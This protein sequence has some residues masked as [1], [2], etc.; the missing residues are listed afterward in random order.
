MLTA[1][2]L[3]PQKAALYHV[4][5]SSRNFYGVLSVVNVDENYLA[6]RYGSTV[7]GFQYRDAQRARLAT[8]YYGPASGANI[9]IR[10]WPQHPM[11]VG[12][13]GLGVGTLAALAQFG[14]VF[15]F[16]EINPDVYKLSTGQQPFFTY[17]RDSPGRIEVI[18]GDARLSL[19]READRGDFQKFDVLVLDAFSSDAIPMHLL[20]R[21]AFY[22]YAKHLRGPASVI[23]VHISNQTLDLGPV[24][25]GI[26]RDFGFHALRVIP[27]LL[28]TS[29]F[30]QSD[31]ILLSRDLA[32]LSGDEIL[33]R[34]EPF[35]AKTRPISW[36]DD[37]CDL[38]HVIRWED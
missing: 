17:L 7:H 13:V 2:L 20:T 37:Y 22:V 3:I 35:P 5:A 18:L 6:L 23:A 34:S 11:R 10:N 24:L 32:S 25:A 4:I 19:E 15:R 27:P 9:V 12:L 14:D 8:G 31:W 28:P 21:E 30:S 16:Y 36:T 26:G 1:G 38:L 33:K 29:P